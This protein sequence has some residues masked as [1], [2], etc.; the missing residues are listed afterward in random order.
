VHHIAHLDLDL[1]P[2]TNH[3]DVGATKLTQQVQRRLRLL[4]QGQTE[5]VLLASLPHRL[6]DVLRNA[7]EPVGRACTVDPLMRSL[8]VVVVDPVLQPTAG[9]GERGKDRLLEVLPPDRLPEPLDLAQRHRMVRSAAHMLNSLLTQDLLE[10]RL[11]A[12]GN[13]LAAVVRQ[14]FAWRSP[15][16]DGTLQD[17]EDSVGILLPEQP[18]AHQIT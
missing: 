12:P 11:A 17:L 9:I 7:V 14:D 13:K 5:R 15:L 6:F 2:L 10:S 3:A 18:P 1:F 16:P 4:A 8:V